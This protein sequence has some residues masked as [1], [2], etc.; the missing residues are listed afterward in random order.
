M[1]KKLSAL[2]IVNN[3]EKQ[4]MDCLKTI[5]FADEIVI[6]LDKCD[7][8]SEKIAKKF[9]KQIF[10][11]CWE[12]EGE[13]RNFGINKCKNE[14]ILEID[15]DE[16]VPTELKNEIINLIQISK[17]DWH[18]IPVKNYVGT[19]IV[20]Y[21]WGA[22]FGKSAYPGLFKKGF[23]SWSYQR[24][25]PKISLSKNKGNTLRNSMI[26]FYCKNIS[27][28]ILKLDSYSNARS[29]DLLMET[30]N[31]TLIKNLRRIFSRFW[32]CYILRKGYKEKKIGIMIALMASLY[33]I[34]SYVKFKLLEKKN[35][36]NSINR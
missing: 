9:T 16:R 18:L 36:K 15:A 26:H 2:V 14:W 5:S 8:E 22:Y 29:I 19:N 11:G 24:V 1:H 32:K 33:P 34:F 6:I 13:R 21:G 25:H 10:K 28:M 4:L 20:N 35:D 3:E 27:D 7:D 23:K 30:K 31:E 12:V 17:Y